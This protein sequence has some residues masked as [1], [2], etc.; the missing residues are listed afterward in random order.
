M[1]SEKGFEEELPQ[2]FLFSNIEVIMI[3]LNA[4]FSQ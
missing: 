3:C 4:A 2:K 1:T